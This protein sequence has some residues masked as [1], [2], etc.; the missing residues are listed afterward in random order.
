M[1]PSGP[2]L[3]LAILAGR[4]DDMRAE[5]MV[6]ISD[7]RMGGDPLHL[8]GTLVGPRRGRDMTLPTTVKL[9]DVT[10][11][12][13]AAG[14]AGQ[15]LARAVFTE[16]AYWTPELPN[17]YRLQA[18]VQ[19]GDQTVAV[20]D[21]MVGLRRLGVRGRSLWLEGRRWVPRG[22]TISPMGFEPT[23]LRSLSA[24]AV[25]DDP[26]DAICEAADQAGVAIIAVLRSVDDQPFDRDTAARRIA[27]WALRPSVV[28]AVV[29]RTANAEESMAIVAGVRPLKGTMLV[30]LEVDGTQPPDAVP[31]LVADAVDCIVVDLPLD[32]L[33]HHG[34][35]LWKANTPL[36]AQRAVATG[37]SVEHRQDCDRLQAA[38]AAWGLAEGA[39]QLPWDWAGYLSAAW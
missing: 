8:T 9:V 37:G 23:S 2:S 20:V 22:V 32:G 12:H 16:P 17:L 15:A 38:L 35:R 6:R 21:R 14:A 34:W 5:I 33:P 24:A 36:V 3:P 18:E 31:A 7:C 13:P 11:D 19:R 28:L 26:S 1:T 39:T 25:I 10:A 30:G 29:P 27:G 4:A